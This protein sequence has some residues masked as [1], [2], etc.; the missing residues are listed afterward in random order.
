MNSDVSYIGCDQQRPHRL[1]EV[2]FPP[3]AAET[4]T[5]KSSTSKPALEM[6]SGLQSEKQGP[7]SQTLLLV[8]FG[9]LMERSR[10]E[11]IKMVN[12]VYFGELYLNLKVFKEKVSEN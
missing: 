9:Y 12:F 1:G 4:Q 8:C 5:E 7:G 3:S 6:A 10:S 11:Q 2:F